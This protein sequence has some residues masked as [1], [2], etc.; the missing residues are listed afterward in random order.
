LIEKKKVSV[1]KRKKQK[2]NEKNKTAKNSGGA[3][4]KFRNPHVSVKSQPQK[5]TISSQSLTKESNHLF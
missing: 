5:K 1:S 2:N 4:E 3:L